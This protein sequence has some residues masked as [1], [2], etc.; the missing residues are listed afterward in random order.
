MRMDM[1]NRKWLIAGAA[2]SAAGV[3]AMRTYQRYRNELDA[4]RTRVMSGS[5]IIE[6]TSGPVEYALTGEGPPVLV[7][8]GA[9]GGYDQ[10]L[11]AAQIGGDNFLYI[12][13]SRSG[14]L[15]TPMAEDP[16]PAA[17]ADAYAALLDALK[18]PKAAIIG[19]SAGGPSSLQFAIRHPERCSALIMV[20]AVSH[21]VPID[22]DMHSCS[23]R[24]LLGN[25][26]RGWLLSTL[27][28]PILLS[29][30]G[31][32]PQVCARLS[33]AQKSWVRRF[34]ATLQPISSKYQGMLNDF[35]QIKIMEPYPLEKITAPTLI[36]HAADDRM[37]PVDHGHLVAN[38]IQ[39]SRFVELSSG[40]HMMI[41][42]HQIIGAEIRFFIEKKAGL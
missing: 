15:G 25:E 30:F 35:E 9:G 17:Q 26:F 23:L 24:W 1:K 14:Y 39:G 22:I 32:T 21:R 33:P 13:M 38:S 29:L 18:I 6:T 10:S 16:S 11:L 31:V 19:I 7:V 28:Q 41:E 8:H 12:A 20:S 5:Q 4:A 40:G 27:M 42:H 36:V 2:G 34:V 37:V 3:I